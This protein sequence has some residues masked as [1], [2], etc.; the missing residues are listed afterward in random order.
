MGLGPDGQDEVKTVIPT[1]WQLMH[2][3]MWALDLFE[4]KRGWRPWLRVREWL[5][6]CERFYKGE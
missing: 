4:E 1:R 2:A 5:T 3:A 6:D